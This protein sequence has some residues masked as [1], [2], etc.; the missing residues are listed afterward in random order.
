MKISIFG[1]SDAT[2]AATPSPAKAAELQEPKAEE[3]VDEAAEEARGG[4]EPTVEKKEEEDQREKEEPPREEEDASPSSTLTGSAT[5]SLTADGKSTYLAF[6]EETH[7]NGGPSTAG[8]GRRKSAAAGGSSRRSASRSSRSRSRSTRRSRSRSTRQGKRSMSKNNKAKKETAPSPPAK[9]AE[10][11]KE[12]RRSRSL[13]PRKLVGSFRKSKKDQTPPPPSSSSSTKEVIMP[14][15]TT[16]DGKSAYLAYLEANHMASVGGSKKNRSSSRSRSRSRPQKSATTEKPKRRS[17]S[18]PR[19]SATTAEKAEKPKRRSLSPRRRSNRIYAQPSPKATKKDLPPADKQSAVAASV[20][21]P[22]V[23][24][25]KSEYLAFLE[26]NH[27]MG[28]SGKKPSGGGGGGS[29]RNLFRSKSKRSSARSVPVDTGAVEE[30]TTKKNADAPVYVETEAVN[31]DDGTKKGIACDE[32]QPPTDD[33]FVEPEEL[34]DVAIA[35]MDTPV[36]SN[37]AEAAT[38]DET[39]SAP[40]TAEVEQETELT[41]SG[42]FDNLLD[43]TSMGFCLASSKS[44]TTVISED[45]M[46]AEDK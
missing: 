28:S 1:A 24:D 2:T 6:L 40:S 29:K 15:M 20:S 37:I 42:F 23:V 32:S 18:R 34:K 10:A 26:A 43:C 7:K 41:K 36:L 3:K 12:E 19:K 27:K 8:R 39:T 16:A 45:L 11:P 30:A 46:P 25:G 17:L 22:A 5:A 44:P 31:L 21:A 33:S 14:D 13:S 35:N 9:E 4:E 38:D